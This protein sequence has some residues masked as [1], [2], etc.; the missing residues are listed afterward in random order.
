[1]FPSHVSEL[2]SITYVVCYRFFFKLQIASTISKTCASILAYP[3]E[4]VRTRLREASVRYTGFF[5]TLRLVYHEEGFRSLYRGLTTQLIRQIPNT[6]IMM[7]TYEVVVDLFSRRY[8]LNQ[9]A[10]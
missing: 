2:M 5:Q 8:I 10:N 1:M 4:V 9:P 6:V 7:V 3:H